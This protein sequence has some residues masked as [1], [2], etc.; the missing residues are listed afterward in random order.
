MKETGVSFLLGVA[1]AMLVVEMIA[2]WRRH[3]ASQ[4][5]RLAERVLEEHGMS[6][7]IYS[8][9][10]G[11]DFGAGELRAALSS[12]ALFDSVVLGKDGAVIGGLVPTMGDLRPLRLVVTED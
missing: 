7:R 11:T 3:Q 1:V 10:I 9:M 12:A 2:A 5:R 8:P 6:A 4:R